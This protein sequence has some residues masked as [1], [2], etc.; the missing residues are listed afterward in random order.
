MSLRSFSR[1]KH[2]CP[3]ASTR[4]IIIVCHLVRQ[5]ANSV[6][7][8]GSLYNQHLNCR[9]HVKVCWFS[10]PSLKIFRIWTRMKLSHYSWNLFPFFFFRF[11]W[12]NTSVAVGGGGSEAGFKTFP[13]PSTVFFVVL[14][15]F[16]GWAAHHGLKQSSNSDKCLLSTQL[17]WFDSATLCLFVFIVTAPEVRSLLL[18]RPFT[19]SLWNVDTHCTL[20][21]LFHSFWTSAVHIFCLSC[22]NR[23]FLAMLRSSAK[24]AR[25]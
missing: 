23:V 22:P 7:W 1:R 13:K 5:L 11:C 6:A 17:L 4:Y 20:R 2:F 14:L 19:F 24:S 25:L 16:L 9:I 3:S 18:L 8:I 10:L 12:G 15:A 21:L